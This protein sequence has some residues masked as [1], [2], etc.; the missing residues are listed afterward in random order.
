MGRCVERTRKAGSVSAQER[1]ARGSNGTE[2]VRS[3]LEAEEA[4][5]VRGTQLGPREWRLSQVSRRK[6]GS[7]RGSRVKLTLRCGH[8][9]W[10]WRWRGRQGDEGVNGAS[11]RCN[12]PEAAALA[13]GSDRCRDRQRECCWGGS[14]GRDHERAVMLAGVFV[15]PCMRS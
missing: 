15:V 12:Q 2:L 1:R 8:R 5:G 9:G 14:E 3:C 7:R 4:A 6:P 11:S 10:R 13:S